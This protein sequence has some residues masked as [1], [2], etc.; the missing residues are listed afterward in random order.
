M[1]NVELHVVVQAEKCHS[2]IFRFFSDVRVFLSSSRAKNQFFPHIMEVLGA[3]VG[4][5][6]VVLV[7]VRGMCQ[8]GKC[9]WN[10]KN[11]DNERENE[12]AVLVYCRCSL[13]S[14]HVIWGLWWCNF[15]KSS[16][17][18]SI[19]AVGCSR[20]NH[21]HHLCHTS[22]WE[23]VDI[24][25]FI[26]AYMI[27]LSIYIYICIYIHKHTYIYICIYPWLRLDYICCLFCGHITTRPK[28]LAPGTEHTA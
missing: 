23:N 4:S 16:T 22:L 21:P 24:K 20:C 14:R 12:V 28:K 8:G 9:F 15:L 10:E 2:L 7:A 6:G 3:T 1:F 13:K 26:N 17:S 18:N 11:T 27:I 5:L 19:S 25:T